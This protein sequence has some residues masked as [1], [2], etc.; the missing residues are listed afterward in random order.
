MVIAVS[1]SFSRSRRGP[2]CPG[3]PRGCASSW[4]SSSPWL[5]VRPPDQPSGS[6]QTPLPAQTC[7][8]V[9]IVLLL[10]V[11]GASAIS[12][13]GR[14][15]SP[16]RRGCACSFPSCPRC[17]GRAGSAVGVDPRA[18]AGAD[19]RVRVHGSSSLQPLGS[20]SPPAAARTRVVVCIGYSS[21]VSPPGPSRSP[22]RRGC[23][24]KLSSSPP[25]SAVGIDRA[26]DAGAELGARGHLDLPAQP[27]SSI[28]A[29]TPART[30]VFVVIVILPASAVVVDPG[31]HARP[32]PGRRAHRRL[33]RRD[34]CRPLCPRGSWCGCSS[35]SPCQ[36]L[37]SMPQPMP[38]CIW[39]WM[40]IVAS[41][42]SRCRRS[43]RRLRREPSSVCS[44]SSLPCWGWIRRG[45]FP[46]PSSRSTPPPRRKCAPWD[47]LR[48]QQGEG[49]RVRDEPC[50]AHRID[51]RATAGAYGS[52]GAHRVLLSMGGEWNAAPDRSGAA[53]GASG[54]AVRIDAASLAGP[55][56][57]RGFHGQS[58]V[59]VD[60]RPVARAHGRA[61]SHRSLRGQRPPWGSRPDPSPA[62]SVV[63]V[64][65]SRSP[66]EAQGAP[67]GSI[68][69][70]SPARR[71][72][73]MGMASA[74]RIEAPAGA[75][76]GVRAGAHVLLRVWV[77]RAGSRPA[78]VG[79][80]P[81]GAE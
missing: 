65:I 72:V 69:D 79:G 50:S 7:V 33:S 23:V 1:W 9:V 45:R 5:V 4:S 22:P 29:P 56:G 66:L 6:M 60:A 68:P 42:V 2:S 74:L 76:L 55:D 64:V 61:R 8:C 39:V 58:A 21:W 63:D 38:A 47:G 10:V 28:R 57:R 59:G 36:P 49:E 81:G 70:P 18:I 43:S 30:R 62:R 37:G 48:G 34:R 3:N 54:G 51:G 19:V 80:T 77:G 17:R 53:G 12:R 11:R 32:D 40:P 71:V 27:L 20:I 67:W 73:V 46:R 16:R 41:R 14:S 78:P 75:C 15:P 26:A 35:P 24:S 25:W 44:S 52:R 31:A 13:W